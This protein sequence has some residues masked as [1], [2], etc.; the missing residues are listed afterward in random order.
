MDI[1]RLVTGTVVGGIA[2]Y[3]LGFLIFDTALREFYAANAGSA[4]GVDRA[5]PLIWAVAVGSVMYAA[6]ITLGIGGRSGATLG[7]GMTVG[8]WSAFSSGAL[9]TS[10]STAS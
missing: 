9:L 7:T 1:K 10:S 6:L 8:Q 4:T 3:G 2:V 5:S